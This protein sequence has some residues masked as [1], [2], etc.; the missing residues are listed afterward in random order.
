[1]PLCHSILLNLITTLG[2]TVVSISRK[3]K[4]GQGEA[5]RGPAGHVGLPGRRR[6]LTPTS[7]LSRSSSGA[8]LAP[9]L[10]DASLGQ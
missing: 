1:M 4:F 2:R 8:V 6:K 5:M 3:Q 7:E 9:A 10:S